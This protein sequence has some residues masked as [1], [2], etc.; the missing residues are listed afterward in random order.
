MSF[1][2]FYSISNS[3]RFIPGKLVLPH[4]PLILGMATPTK[5]CVTTPH[6]IYHADPFFTE[7]YAQT[8]CEGQ[9]NWLEHLPIRTGLWVWASGTLGLSSVPWIPAA[10]LAS[11]YP[12]SFKIRMI[13]H[14][15][16]G[17][18]AFAYHQTWE[19]TAWALIISVN[20]RQVLKYYTKYS[21]CYTIPAKLEIISQIWASLN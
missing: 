12:T 3:C 19:A 7:R 13:V 17:G 11:I 20:R 15:V 18:I 16:V 2:Y 21:C 8:W 9:S 14:L 5:F 4:E 1:R 10:S 6:T